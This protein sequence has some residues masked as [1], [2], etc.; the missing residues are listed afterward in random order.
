MIKSMILSV[1]DFRAKSG[2]VVSPFATT[3]ISARGVLRIEQEHYA[4]KYPMLMRTCA[5]RPHRQPFRLPKGLGHER[6]SVFRRLFEHG[7]C[8]EPAPRMQTVDVEKEQTR[9]RVDVEI[10]SVTLRLEEI[11]IGARGA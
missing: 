5:G 8:P 7:C 11:E 9:R 1:F 3:F 10:R 2:S 4:Y 6:D